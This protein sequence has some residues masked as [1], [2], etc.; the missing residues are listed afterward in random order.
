MLIERIKNHGTTTIASSGTKSGAID[1]ADYA[2]CICYLP[3]SL[4]GT[5]ITFEVSH[6]GTTFVPLY[7]ASGAAVSRTVAASRA[8]YV[9]PEVMAAKQFKLVSGSSEGAARTIA[10]SMMT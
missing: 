8:F 9:P 5:A 2:I 6:D 7:D 10:Y 3:A 1:T 4:T